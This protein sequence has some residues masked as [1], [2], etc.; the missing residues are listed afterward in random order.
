MDDDVR[1]SKRRGLSTKRLRG[2]ERGKIG[3]VDEPIILE[4]IMLPQLT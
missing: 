3:P 1:L 2:F 4:E